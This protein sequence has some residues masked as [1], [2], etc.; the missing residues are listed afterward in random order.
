MKPAAGMGFPM[1][2][3]LKP[4]KKTETENHD[5][6]DAQ[7]DVSF[8]KFVLLMLVENHRFFPKKS[9]EASHVT[10]SRPKTMMAVPGMA[11]GNNF[12]AEL[13]KKKQNKKP[14]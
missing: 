2:G 1:M 8:F 6:K 13:K 14:V 3:G 10:K 9:D 12:L 7:D 5:K 11:M 4:L